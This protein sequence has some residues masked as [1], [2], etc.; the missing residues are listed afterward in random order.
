LSVSFF[1]GDSHAIYTI[2]VINIISSTV[3]RYQRT[4]I[5]HLCCRVISIMQIRYSQ[6]KHQQNLSPWR[7]SA[8]VSSV[9]RGKK[10]VRRILRSFSKIQNLDKNSRNIVGT[11]SSKQLFK[12]IYRDQNC[13]VSFTRNDSAIFNR[14]HLSVINFLEGLF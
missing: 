11:I 2:V 3:S 6:E 13:R 8:F 4:F 12:L 9:I 14:P 5:F 7:M 1:S 10:V